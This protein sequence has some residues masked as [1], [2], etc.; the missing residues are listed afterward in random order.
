[1]RRI[2][3]AVVTVVLTGFLPAT[4]L[5][6]GDRLARPPAAVRPGR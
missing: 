4:A 1:M 6:Q 2:T 3:A 5:A